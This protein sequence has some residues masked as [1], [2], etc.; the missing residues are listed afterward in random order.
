MWSLFTNKFRHTGLRRQFLEQIIFNSFQGN[1][2]R[3]D[4]AR[5]TVTRCDELSPLCKKII[6]NFNSKLNRTV[7]GKS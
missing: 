1:R 5:T 7:F 4:E 3:R 6:P 2:L